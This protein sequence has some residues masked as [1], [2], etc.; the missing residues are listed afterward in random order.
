MIVSRYYKYRLYPNASQRADLTKMFGAVRFVANRTIEGVLAKIDDDGYRFDY[1]SEANS[2][3][4]LKASFPFLKDAES[5]SL[6]QCLKHVGLAVKRYFMHLGGKP[7]Y[8]SKKNRQSMTI[9]AVGKNIRIADEKHLRL[10]KIGNVRFVYHRPLPFKSK[11]TSMCVSEEVDGRFFASI[12]VEFEIDA[13]NKPLDSRNAVGLDYKSDGLYISSDGVLASM[14]HYFR[15]AQWNLK[16]KQKRLSRTKPGSKN[17]EK[18]RIKA[19]RVASR[20]ADRRKDFLDKASH[21]LAERYDVVSVEDIDMRSMK[22]SLR[23]GKATSDNGYGAFR[24]MLEYKLSDRRK[25]FVKVGR[26]FASSQTCHVCGYKD[27]I[28][29]NLNIREWDC[30]ICGSHNDRDLNAALN[31]RDEGL[32]ILRNNTEGRSG[33]EAC[34]ETPNGKEATL[35]REVP[36]K[37]EAPT[38]NSSR[39]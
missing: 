29:K 23:L 7:N 34:G 36:S 4:V 31:I 6:Q 19:A 14:P 13:K 3:I 11:I 26:F 28:T 22:K 5:T 10:P 9:C 21:E 27:S 37:Q 25:A 24:R 17:H 8:V 15:K 2:L 38:S 32:R 39:N 1:Y 30:P 20:V 12:R 33:I 35:C 18:A 16:Q